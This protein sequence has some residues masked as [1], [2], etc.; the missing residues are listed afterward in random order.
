M[1]LVEFADDLPFDIVEDMKVFMRNDKDFYRRHYMPCMVDLQT[2]VKAK[3][4]NFGPVLKPMVLQACA[5]YNSKY[6]ISKDPNKLLTLDDKKAL[7]SSIC[8]EEMEKL[9]NGEY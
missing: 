1:R 3:D 7:M 4:S 9:R 6:K 8:R 5:M 2:K